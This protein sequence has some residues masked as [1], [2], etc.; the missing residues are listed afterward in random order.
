MLNAHRVLADQQR[1]E[2]L[3]RPHD[4]QFAPGNASLTHTVNAFI[5]VYDDKQ[6]VAKATPH[7]VAFNIGN[8]HLIPPHAIFGKIWVGACCRFIALHQIHHIIR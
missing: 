1:F 2:V 8:L 7:R 5:G 6:K 3:N 4:R